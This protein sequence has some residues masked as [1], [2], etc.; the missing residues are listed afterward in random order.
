MNAHKTTIDFE[1][2]AYEAFGGISNDIMNAVSRAAGS[3][4]YLQ[5]MG[6]PLFEFEVE[7][8]NLQEIGDYNINDF[9]NNL[10]NLN[11]QSDHEV[12]TGITYNFKL[13]VYK[14]RNSYLIK[15]ITNRVHVKGG[16]VEI[17]T[18]QRLNSEEARSLLDVDFYV[19][20]S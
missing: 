8:L 16:K 20:Y 4:F 11:Q 15:D 14:F 17:F 1:K 19:D 6:K 2:L 12:F 7:V 13:D 5:D 3:N 18:S 10:P 9:I